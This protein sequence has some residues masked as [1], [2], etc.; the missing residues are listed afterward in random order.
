MASAGSLRAEPKDVSEVGQFITLE[1]G[2][3][4]GKSTLIQGLL[5]ELERNG[6]TVDVTREP[7]EQRSQNTSARSL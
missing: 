1:G 2:E 4:T 7:A 3:G 5:R 6:L